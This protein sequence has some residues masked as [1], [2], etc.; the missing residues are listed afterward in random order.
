MKPVLPWDDI[1]IWRKLLASWRGVCAA[2]WKPNET[3]MLG[4]DWADPHLCG[5]CWCRKED[6][7]TFQYQ[8]T[9][10]IKAKKDFRRSQGE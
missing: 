5:N 8:L 10:Q 2:C 9:Q 3:I 1:S 4:D 7:R 6:R